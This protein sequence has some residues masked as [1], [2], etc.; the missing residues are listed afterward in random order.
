MPSSTLATVSHASTEGSSDSKMSFQRITTIGS[1]P[2][3]NRAATALA[4]EPV[5]LVLEPVDLDQVAGEVDAR[6]AA[7]RSAVGDLVGGADEHVGDSG[8]LLHRRLDAV[9]AELVGRLLGEVDDVVKR[10]G[11]RVDVGGLE[12]VRAGA[13]FG[14]PVQDVVGD[15]VAL[16]FAE[17]D[18]AR[19]AGLVGIVREQVAQQRRH[20]LTL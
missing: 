3:A 11:E 18:V 15:A 20:A 16:V 4:D 5:G 9:A 19:E 2:L 10:A 17:Q 7:P 8:R 6:R 12:R 14:Q 13:A 1:I